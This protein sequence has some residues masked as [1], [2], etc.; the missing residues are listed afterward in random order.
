MQAAPVWEEE[1]KNHH[2]HEAAR[3]KEGRDE[4]RAL[5]AEEY[6]PSGDDG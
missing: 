5:E 6:H 4:A 1:E 3:W 2:P